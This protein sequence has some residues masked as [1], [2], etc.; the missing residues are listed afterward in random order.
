MINS[1][2][3]MTDDTLETHARTRIPA[4]CWQCRFPIAAGQKYSGGGLS[5][6]CGPCLIFR[7]RQRVADARTILEAE[8]AEL[9]GLESTLAAATLEAGSGDGGVG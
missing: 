2:K 6:M 4:E 5:L 7:A 8:E 9:A 3:T 1:I